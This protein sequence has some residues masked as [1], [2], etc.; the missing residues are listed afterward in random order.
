MENA[1]L[2]GLSQQTALQRNLDII[3][4]NLANM[5]TNAYKAERPLF[6]SYLTADPRRSRA[7]RRC[8]DG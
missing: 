8:T 4:H 3:A 2:I 6:H 7:P 1:L 5:E